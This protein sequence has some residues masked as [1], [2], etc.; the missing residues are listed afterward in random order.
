MRVLSHPNVVDL[1]A[2]FYT[3]GEK[4]CDNLLTIRKMKCI[5]TWY[6]NTYQRLYIVLRV[7]IPR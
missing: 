1:R 2:F 7:I 3:S 5:L 4:V 6:W